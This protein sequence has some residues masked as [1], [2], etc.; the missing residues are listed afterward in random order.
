MVQEL[1]ERIAHGSYVVDAD[2]V[3]AAMLARRRVHTTRSGM[4]IASEAVEGTAFRVP[5]RDTC[6]G[7]DR[8]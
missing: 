1:Q 3:A 5:D 2:A 7:D 4:L 6:T 8:A